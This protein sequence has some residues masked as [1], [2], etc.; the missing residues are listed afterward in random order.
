MSFKGKIDCLRG[1]FKG[2]DRVAIAFSGGTDSTLLSMIAGD[3]LGR[4][5]VLLC[6]V[7]SSFQKQTNRKRALDFSKEH[8]L[9][10]LELLYPNT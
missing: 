6:F 1:F 2:I 9:N 4:D 10:L 7:N 5:N 3:A 8:G